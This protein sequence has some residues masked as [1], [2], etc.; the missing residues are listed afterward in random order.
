MNILETYGEIIFNETNRLC[1]NNIIHVENGTIYNY[2]KGCFDNQLH[3]GTL[4]RE[5]KKEFHI[6]ANKQEICNIFMEGIQIESNETYKK[7]A[8]K[9]EC[10]IDEISETN[11]VF[12]TKQYL[13]LCVQILL[14]S[15]RKD[16][17]KIKTIDQCFT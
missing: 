2:K 15:L 1:K 8:N 16:L 3:I 5:E 9:P 17:E 10:N 11:N 14:Y 7:I 6:L 12:V 4:S 13:R